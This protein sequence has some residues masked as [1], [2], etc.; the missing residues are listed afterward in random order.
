MLRQ[1]PRDFLEVDMLLSAI[2]QHGD[3]CGGYTL[4]TAS[5]DD[6]S[7]YSSAYVTLMYEQVIPEKTPTLEFEVKLV[8]AKKGIGYDSKGVM[9][10]NGVLKFTD[11]STYQK[12]FEVTKKTV[13][14]V[15][16]EPYSGS[17]TKDKKENRYVFERVS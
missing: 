3:M 7:N 12:K 10:I 13:K 14:V 4:K 6:P 9:P 15:E 17:Y 16:I 11:G 8:I 1:L 5:G 2:E